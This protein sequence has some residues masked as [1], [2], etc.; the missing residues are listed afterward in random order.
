MSFVK[1]E[2]TARLDDLYR[3]GM[4]AVGVFDDLAQSID[5]ADLENLVASHASAQRT[6]LERAAA[7]RRAR[8]EM[9]H[10]ADPERSHLE[11][12]GAFVRAVLLP[13]QTAAH[14]VETLLEAVRKVDRHLDAALALDLDAKLRRVLEALRDDN[15]AFDEALRKRL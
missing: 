1:D 4:E 3:E 14:Y 15:A 7:L 11:A 6:L 13:G 8:G 10:A 2:A 9:P 12:A 5:D